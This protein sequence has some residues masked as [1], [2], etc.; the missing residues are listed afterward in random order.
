[1]VV[2]FIP[3]QSLKTVP[4]FSINQLSCSESLSGD[5]EQE[6]S[7]F[8]PSLLVLFLRGCHPKRSASLSGRQACYSNDVDR[9]KR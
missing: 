3:N 8:E 9:E 5:S 7:G 2:L 1:M 6:K 4:D